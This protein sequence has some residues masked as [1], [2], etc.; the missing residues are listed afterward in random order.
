MIEKREPPDWKTKTS[1]KR[2]QKQ[3]AFKLKGIFFGCEQSDWLNPFAC[4]A[5]RLSQITL[6]RS[7]QTFRFRPWE[8]K[9]LWSSKWHF[10]QG[11]ISACTPQWR[12]VY[13]NKICT[14]L[15]GNSKY[16]RNI[17]RRE[18]LRAKNARACLQLR[19]ILSFIRSWS[20]LK[21]FHYVKCVKSLWKVRVYTNMK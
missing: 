16:K 10:L 15:T 17:R 8:S 7:Y 14:S 20:T 6:L 1:R 21:G 11:W 9:L 3:K 12:Q 13:L 19:V 5:N 18:A 4:H 2:K